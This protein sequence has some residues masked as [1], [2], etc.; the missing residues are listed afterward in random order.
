LEQELE[1]PR[2]E[3]F[4]VFALVAPGPTLEVARPYCDHML[5][6]L[7]GMVDADLAPPPVAL[8]FHTHHDH[9]IEA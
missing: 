5:R 8:I 2:D 9:L 4:H 3:V 6:P 7:S 1:A